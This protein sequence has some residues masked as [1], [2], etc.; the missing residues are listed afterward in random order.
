MVVLVFVGHAKV[1]A[2]LVQKVRLGQLHAF[3]FE[4]VAHIED[5]AV[6]AF[7]Q[8]GMVVEHA[9]GVAAVV[10]EGEAFD[11]GGLIA[12]RRVQGHLHARSGAAVHG[13]Q[14]VCAQSHGALACLEWG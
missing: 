7:A 12:L 9:V 13:V 2:D 1:E 5:Q 10:V 3:G 6:S 4:V 8:A 14:N 11:Q